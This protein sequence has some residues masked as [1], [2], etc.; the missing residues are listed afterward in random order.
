MQIFMPSYGK[1]YS[2]QAQLQLV[3]AEIGLHI[4]YIINLLSKSCISQAVNCL[5][6]C[7]GGKKNSSESLEDTLPGSIFKIYFSFKHIT[8]F[9]IRLD[10]KSSDLDFL[11]KS[12]NVDCLASWGLGFFCFLMV[13]HFPRALLLRTGG[14]SGAGHSGPSHSVIAI[15]FLPTGFFEE[16]S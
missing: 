7:R 4:Q 5:S 15:G 14:A 11:T 3:N 16:Y 2:L 12:P 13:T 10:L 1:S 8:N 9:K 6:I